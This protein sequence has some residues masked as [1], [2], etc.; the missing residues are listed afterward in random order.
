MEIILQVKNDS[1]YWLNIELFDYQKPKYNFLV[2]DIGTPSTR[3]LNHSNT[4]AIRPTGNNFRNLG[5]NRFNLDNTAIR[6]NKKYDYKLLHGG[7]TVNSGVLVINNI[8]EDSINVNLIDNSVNLLDFWGDT[9]A[10]S[11][12]TDPNITSFLP[13][14]YN[15]FLNVLRSYTIPALNVP[16]L[17]TGT[18]SGKNY[19]IASFPNTLNCIG[20]KFNANSNSARFA[21]GIN[22]YQTRP[23][24]SAKAL[25]EIACYYSGYTPEFSPEINSNLFLDS[26]YI[27]PKAQQKKVED[28]QDFAWYP[29]SPVNFYREW[30]NEL[31]D[32]Y[33][34]LHTYSA[35]SNALA[36]ASV[37]GWFNPPGIYSG[38]EIYKTIHSIQN[39]NNFIG[40][41]S[42]DITITE[43]FVGSPIGYFVW[44]NS[45]GT[46]PVFKSA[47]VTLS[48][49]DG[50]NFDVSV[51]KSEALP[52]P[53]DAGEF[54]GIMIG[55]T[56]ATETAS[57][58]T[59]DPVSNAKET[60]VINFSVAYDI[61]LQYPQGVLNLLQEAPEES[62]LKLV[63]GIIKQ[64]GILL[65]INSS[66]NNVYFY[67]YQDIINNKN[68]YVFDDW[69]D[70]FIKVLA[71]DTVFGEQFGQVNVIGLNNPFRGNTFS[72]QLPG[73][74]STSKYK[75]SSEFLNDTYTDVEEALITSINTGT[76]P[77]QYIEYTNKGLGLVEKTG[78]INGLHQTKVDNNTG[79]NING[80]PLMQNVNYAI[81]PEGVDIWFNLVASSVKLTVLM[82][83]PFDVINK[84]DPKI[85]IYIKDIGRYFIV[86]SIKEYEDGQTPV[87][88]QL[89]HI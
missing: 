34:F 50:F 21:N 11:M 9:S 52:I 68:D 35:D 10:K 29:D 39:P 42:M 4:L 69:S 7:R 83:L 17:V 23:L 89:I 26:I 59:I 86:N 5:L 74:G 28:L 65:D 45:A 63:S 85:P 20:E 62:I 80:I 15:D 76:S 16:F 8:L 37:P 56:L 64:Q 31:Y 77:P 40:I 12:F 82:L 25:L 38:H 18:I 41:V 2:G 87:E 36:A 13:G 75:A 22:L 32:L 70:Y 78:A 53:N 3:K 51:D 72:K 60:F 81:L 14:V 48:S 66:T 30:T 47:T 61:N 79:A 57:L 71:D 46:A 1:G 43:I 55:Y 88:V 33:D 19:P 44:L 6:L 24:W 73:H 67:T 49:V 58:P 84:F 27:V 54:L